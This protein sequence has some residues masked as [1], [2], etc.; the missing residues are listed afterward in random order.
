ML[1]F[2]SIG[3]MAMP[4]VGSFGRSAHMGFSELAN[5]M[6]NWPG[7]SQRMILENYSNYW[8]LRTSGVL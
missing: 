3:N 7:G 5:W 1:Q 4:L 2:F 8:R 6:Q